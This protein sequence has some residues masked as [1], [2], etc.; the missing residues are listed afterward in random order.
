MTVYL[1][2]LMLLNFLVDFLLLLGTNRLYGFPSQPGRTAAAAALGGIYAGAC[3]LPGFRFLGNLL[4]RVVS[5]LLM[6]G[7]A[8]G[9]SRSAAKRTGIFLV[10]TMALGGTALSLGK[11]NLLSLLPAGALMWLLCRLCL[12]DAAGR[13]YVPLELSYGE[14]KLQLV[15]LQ[16]TGNTL[17][18]PISGEQVLVISPEA[19]EEL[20]GLTREQLSRPLETM[21]SRVL[22]GLRL[23]PYKAVGSAGMLLAMRFP[24]ARIGSR[25]RSSLV[26]FAP[27]GFG[28]GEIVQALTGGH[29]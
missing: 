15:A 1:D 6:G 2:L 23:V 26:A 12:A 11:G 22:P 28:R 29:V 8:F 18:D 24:E 4:W 9:W 16:D 7:I 27:E 13:E 25:Q 21:T 20:T 19:A 14:R 10:L 5:L 17:R 3:L